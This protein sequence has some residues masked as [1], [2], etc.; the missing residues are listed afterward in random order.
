MERIDIAQWSRLWEDL[1]LRGDSQAWYSL[2]LAA[3]AEPHRRYHTSEH[4][5]ECLATFDTLQHLAAHPRLV[6]FALWFHDAVYN[7]R[8]TDNEEQSAELAL[9]CLTKAGGSVNHSAQV[10]DL[11]L[12]TKT[13]RPISADTRAICDA[14][15][16]ILGQPAERYWRYEYAIAEE[17]SWVPVETYRMKRAEI[18]SQF[19]AA[20]ALYHTAPA[21]DRF[22]SAARIN[23]TEA[24][25]RLG[26]PNA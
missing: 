19:L 14:D 7:P 17:Y 18:L 22:E 26:S 11:I 12:V 24:I 1:H 6:E 4:L 10:R 2:L 20:D 25:A 9:S 8:A 13:H 5:A 23:L 15:L 3:H 16:A 21:R